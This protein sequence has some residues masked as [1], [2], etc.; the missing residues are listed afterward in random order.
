MDIVLQEFINLS[1]DTLS[2]TNKKTFSQLLDKN[3]L[4]IL[5]W[6]MG[7]DEPENDEIR[8]IIKLIRESRNI[9]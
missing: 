3:D 7:K 1:Y 9:N 5:N 8:H 6:I 2:D 4:D